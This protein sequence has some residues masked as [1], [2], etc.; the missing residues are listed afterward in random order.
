MLV[1]CGVSYH[2]RPPP[3]HRIL[4]LHQEYTRRP[5][6]VDTTVTEQ[7]CPVRTSWYGKRPQNHL[8]R[9]HCFPSLASIRSSHRQHHRRFYSHSRR[10]D[11]C[12]YCVHQQRFLCIARPR[13]H[14]AALL[15]NAGSVLALEL[16]L[17]G[18][19]L[20]CFYQKNYQRTRPDLH[21]QASRAFHLEG[22][23]LVG[24][25]GFRD[26]APTVRQVA[27]AFHLK[28]RTLVGNAGS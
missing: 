4:P 17:L 23:R 8:Q 22:R 15:I 1:Q 26:S 5:M 9:R 2:R 20:T 19:F 24:N 14:Y 18:I 27:R 10:R 6:N 12:Y 7:S 11:R 28:R 21:L 16:T 13:E 3:Y 25:A